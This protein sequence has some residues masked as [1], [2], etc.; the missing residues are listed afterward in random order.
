MQA[1]LQSSPPVSQVHT[2]PFDV[3]R[4]EE[5]VPGQGQMAV[6]LQPGVTLLSLHTYL[7]GQGYECSFA[8]GGRRLPCLQGD[9]V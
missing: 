7:A 4:P 2:Y 6:R 1:A 8:P 9:H 5:L 3:V